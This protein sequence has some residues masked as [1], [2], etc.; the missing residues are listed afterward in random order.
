MPERILIC[1]HPWPDLRIEREILSGAGLEAVEAPDPSEATLASL[2]ADVRGIVTCFARVTARVIAA[3]ADLAIVA[4]FGTGV[5]MIDLDAARG[6]GAVVTNVPEYCTDEVAE[7]ALALLLALV[8]GV[9]RLDG[10]VR[11]GRWSADPGP[12][13]RI[14]GSTVG[15]VGFGKTGRALARRLSA[16]GAEVLV[17]ARRRDDEAAGVRHVGLDELLASCDAISLHLPLTDETAGLVDEA[18]LRKM[19]PGAVLVNTARGGLV[20]S[21]ALAAALRSGHLGGA[22][23]DVLPAE[24]PADEPLLDAPNLVVT[25]HVAYISEAS[26]ATLRRLACEDVVRVVAE[27]RPP[28]RPV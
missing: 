12:L 22:A 18:F 3:P 14:V 4:R 9:V 5:D 17:H 10:Q 25:P 21:A 26:V 28:L 16:L 11:A 13:G 24:P 27:G 7:H 15:V 1:D 23:V 6:R 19:R 8:R 2:A 20:D